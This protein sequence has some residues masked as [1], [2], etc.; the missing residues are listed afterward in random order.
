MA[1]PYAQYEDPTAPYKSDLSAQLAALLATAKQEDT[2]QNPMIQA[3][4][5]AQSVPS[6]RNGLGQETYDPYSN[7]LKTL[8]S[9]L[10]G[11]VG[12]GQVRDSQNARLDAMNQALTSPG[13]LST[14]AASDDPFQKQMLAAALLDKSRKQEDLNFALKKIGATQA[15]ELQSHVLEN[16]GSVIDPSNGQVTQIPTAIDAMRA[17]AAAKAPP[18]GTVFP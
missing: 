14:L 6:L 16:M 4:V 7:A 5:T 12:M 17:V 9:S 11:S 15:G 2:R 10:L 1:D 18:K 13:G 8:A 3:A